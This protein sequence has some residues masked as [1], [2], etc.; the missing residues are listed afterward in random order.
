MSFLP[1]PAVAEAADDLLAAARSLVDA[2]STTLLADDAV[3]VSC[4]AGCSAC[5]SQAVPVT[6]AE[7]RSVVAAVG[8]LPDDRRSDVARRVAAVNGYLTEAGVSAATFTAAAADP[9]ARR[10]VARRYFGLDLPCPLLFDGVCSVRADRPLACRQY[11]V[12][13]DPVHCSPPGDTIE[14]VVR[15]GSRSDVLRGFAEVSRVFGESRHQI[16][17]FALADAQ[18]SGPPVAPPAEARSGPRMAT[19]LT[20][21][22]T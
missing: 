4:R 2:A 18:R 11:L 14:Q 5:C 21:P 6:P 19:M 8:R 13:S 16:L 22:A 1:V 7:V 17:V 20:P 9:D 10:V 15:I 3:G 12:S